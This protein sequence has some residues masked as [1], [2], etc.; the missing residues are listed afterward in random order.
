MVSV[1]VPILYLAVLIGSLGTFSYFYRRR[2]LSA[3]SQP[4][5]DDWFPPNHARDLY[6]SLMSHPD[7]ADAKS[8]P[9][10]TTPEAAAA[11]A[12]E[13]KTW[14]KTQ[15]LKAALLMRAYEDIKRLN[16]LNARKQALH[17]LVQNGRASDD[18]WRRMLSAEE[19]L[20]A[21]LMDV[22]SEAGAL[23]E[24]W[25]QIIFATANEMQLNNDIRDRLEGL[26]GLA[27]RTRQDYMQDA[28][29]RAVRATKAKARREER[30]RLENVEGTT[31]APAKA[32]KDVS[33]SSTDALEVDGGK[34]VATGASAS[35]SAAKRRK[36]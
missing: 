2:K 30:E 18:L 36:N 31:T 20:K 29:A 22:V 12:A 16:E 6:F 32:A 17:N 15:L 34:A 13:R 5:L 10:P 26:V 11:A 25:G 19:E 35:P 28:D 3:E 14:S 9:I 33:D 1:F 7:L 23:Q 21:E 27:Q 24:G 8:P 4:Q